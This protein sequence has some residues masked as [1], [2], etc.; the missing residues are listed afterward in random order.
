MA[1]PPDPVEPDPTPT[2]AP[3]DE[4]VIDDDEQSTEPE[5]ADV[6][7]EPEAAAEEELIVGVLTDTQYTNTA[8]GISFL[9]PE[10]SKFAEEYHPEV[11]KETLQME[12]TTWDVYAMGMKKDARNYFGV[13]Y[14]DLA[15]DGIDAPISEEAYGALYEER[16]KGSEVFQGV[17]FVLESLELAGETYVVLS[18]DATQTVVGRYIREYY[19]LLG[20]KYMM[21]IT[22]SGTSVE[23]VDEIATLLTTL[24]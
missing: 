7:A 6:P 24:N 20:T 16:Y 5:D 15:Q 17:E 10:G 3:T 14:T 13:L 4:P 21:T 9:L 22:I 19:K 12:A 2:I 23:I 8:L 11:T 18:Y 1:P